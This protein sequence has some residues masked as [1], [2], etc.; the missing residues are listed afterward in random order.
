M[1]LEQATPL[2]R[3]TP[4]PSPFGRSRRATST[5]P[6]ANRVDPV[7]HALEAANSVPKLL[8]PEQVATL[9]GVTE[10]TLERWRMT[11]D[12]PPYVGL[13]RRTVRYSE[14]ALIAFVAARVKENT[15]Q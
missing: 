3:F 11:G 14:A 8:T 10:R 7:E 5:A 13:T 12:G 9:L 1:N 4:S 6:T 15:A 2:K